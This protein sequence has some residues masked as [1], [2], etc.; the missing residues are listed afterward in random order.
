MNDKVENLDIPGFLRSHDKD[1]NPISAFPGVIDDMAKARSGIGTKS[2]TIED[3][4]RTL[5]TLGDHNNLVDRA[6]HQRQYAFLLAQRAALIVD[7][8]RLEKLVY[9]PGQLR[10]AKCE[11]VVLSTTLHAPTGTFSANNEPQ[12][13]PNGCGPMWRVTERDAGNEVCNRLEKAMDAL[14]IIRDACNRD[15]LFAQFTRQSFWHAHHV[16][17][18]WR[19]DGKDVRHQADWFKDVWYALKA[20]FEPKAPHTRDAA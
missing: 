5:A 4:R 12:A 3:C 10:C 11:C 13:C 15:S 18:L 19:H 6:T 1:G 8:E 16:D 2:V 7:I 17:I 9:V 14:I 20:I